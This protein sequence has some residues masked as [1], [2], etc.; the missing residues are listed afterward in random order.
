MPGGGGRPAGAWAPP[1]API[2]GSRSD[3][4]ANC[5]ALRVVYRQVAFLL[6]CDLEAVAEE[7]LVDR[8][9][10]SRPMC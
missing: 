3:D 1:A 2:A 5:V 8:A 4:N 9:P 7:R 10:A 6:A